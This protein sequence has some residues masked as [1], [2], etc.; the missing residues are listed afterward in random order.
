MNSINSSGTPAASRVS[1]YTRGVGTGV[2]S[3]AD[4]IRASRATSCADANSSPSGGRRNTHVRPCPSRTRKG[5]VDCPSPIRS[6][7]SGPV[8]AIPSCSIQSATS[9]VLI[10]TT[11]WLPTD[12][13]SG[14]EHQ[15]IAEQLTPVE[16]QGLAGDPTGLIR[17]QEGDRGG[18]VGRFTDPPQRSGGRQSLLMVL[19]Q[20][21]GKPGA[22]HT[23]ADRVDPN[24]R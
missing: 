5:R 2:S 16:H 15:R 13:G 6:K 22:N 10:P 9:A 11:L 24:P 1:P 20:R 3:S 14:A 18:H 17:H 12:T 23:G 8:N 4:R 21:L 19:P 7:L